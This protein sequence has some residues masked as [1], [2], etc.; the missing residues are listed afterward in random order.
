M[1][2]L[3]HNNQYIVRDDDELV[4]GLLEVAEL[5]DAAEDGGGDGAFAEAVSPEGRL[6]YRCG[7]VGQPGVQPPTVC[8]AGILR[9]LVKGL[10]PHGL[11]AVGNG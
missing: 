3:Y 10:S 1:S 2:E 6:D 7:G 5:E 9:I 8:H 4:L 11:L